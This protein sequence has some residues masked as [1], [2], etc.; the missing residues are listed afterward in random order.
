[1]RVF[2]ESISRLETIRRFALS[3]RTFLTAA[4]TTLSPYQLRRMIMTRFLLSCCCLVSLGLPAFAADDD[5]LIE[6]AQKHF[7]RNELDKALPLL[8]KAI[9]SNPKNAKAYS[10][11]GAIH[12]RMDK[13]KEAIADY[14]KAIELDP[15]DARTINDRGSAHF[16]NGQIKESVADFDKFLELR[17]REGAGHWQRG[18]SLYYV[19]RFEDGMKQFKA[20]EEKD[21]N[22]VENAVWHFLCNARKNGV[23]KAQKEILKIGD[24]RRIPM[25]QI[26]AL[27]AG[28]KKPEDVM[29]AVEEGKPGEKER[30]YRLFYAHLYLGLYYEVQ[31]DKKLA[32]QHLAEAADKYRINHYMWDVARVHRDL[33]KK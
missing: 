4:T 21:T 6:E 1:M 13:Y 29:K 19:E 5:K 33:L 28:T 16:K 31:G 3:R 8:A 2:T 22:D 14:T 17:P 10:L 18:I 26:Y 24:D 20:Y 12:E 32:L 23:A 25:M 15:K 27:Y 7:T 11:R 9:E 30:N